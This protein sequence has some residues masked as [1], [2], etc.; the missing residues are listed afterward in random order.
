MSLR[1][2][3]KKK[4]RTIEDIKEILKKHDLSF[5]EVLRNAEDGMRNPSNFWKSLTPEEKIEQTASILAQWTA[6]E[7]RVEHL[8]ERFGVEPSP[9]AEMVEGVDIGRAQKALGLYLGE[10][11]KNDP[12][13][14]TA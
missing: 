9:Y 2:T 8:A 13:D 5:T 10:C 14:L 3:K 11:I 7:S 4:M 1:Q 6:D 12:I